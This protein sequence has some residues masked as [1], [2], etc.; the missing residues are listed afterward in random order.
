MSVPDPTP[1]RKPRRLFLYLP[2]VLL[3]VAAA[4]WTGFWVYARS[5]AQARM[6]AAVAELGRAG[7]RI[8]WG[9]RSIGGYPFRLDVTLTDAVVREPSGWAL[10]T[11]RLEGEAYLYAPTRWVLAAPQGLTFVRPESGPVS[12]RAMNIRASL[13]ALE[14]RPPSV[15]LQ[16]VEATFQPPAGGQ[17]FALQSAGKVELHLRAGPNDEGG[18]FVSV[19]N[20]RAQPGGLLGRIAGDKPVSLAW[21]STLSKISAFQGGDWGA[22]V[23]SW[24]DA[25]GV[26]TV[27]PGTQLAAGDALAAVRA[28]TL[29]AGGDGRL[30]GELDVTL[31]QAPQALAAMAA[32]GAAPQGAA[33]MAG[34]VAAARQEGDSARAA[35]R[36]EAGRTTLGP[37]AL[38][39]APKVYTP[40]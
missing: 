3:L 10:E 4:A 15:S 40:R 5:A 32:I 30:R 2:F 6:D 12:V 35:I 23:R 20:G 38:W 25:G 11:P 26:M 29:R 8:A 16:L 33:Q 19:E 36:F 1:S 17:S 7:Y 27:R 9:K 31:R 14:A 28:G 37:V 18:V 13:G 21:N 22:A 24:A 34:V 39:P